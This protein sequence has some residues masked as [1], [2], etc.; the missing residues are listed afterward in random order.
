MWCGG[1]SAGHRARLCHR[2][3]HPPTQGPAGQ[4]P[5]TE[6]GAGAL[7]LTPRPPGGPRPVG[8]RVDR[9]S[10]VGGSRGSRTDAWSTTQAWCF[11]LKE[12]AWRPVAPM[13]KARTNHASAALNGEIY[14]VGGKAPP[15]A[16]PPAAAPRPRASSGA[17]QAGVP[18]PS[19]RLLPC[20]LGRREQDKESVPQPREE[21][22]S[23]LPMGVATLTPG[24]GLGPQLGVTS[25]VTSLGRGDPRGTLSLSP[26]LQTPPA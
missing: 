22:G 8:A 14:A 21:P 1:V 17:A 18:G 11:P 4:R 15:R 5:G 6:E 7:V 23:Q 10:L 2:G 13:L 12:A 3:H 9:A 16:P 19:S 20:F 26:G 25:S 24:P